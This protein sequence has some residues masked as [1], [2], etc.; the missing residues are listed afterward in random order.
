MFRASSSPLAR[1]LP[2]SGAINS[3]LHHGPATQSI[4]LVLSLTLSGGCGEASVS[5]PPGADGGGEHDASADGTAPDASIDGGDANPA[6][7]GPATRIDGGAEIDPGPRVD[8]GVDRDGG[9]EPDGGPAPD[10]G[11]ISDA[12]SPPSPLRVYLHPSGDDTQDGLTEASAVLTLVRV[13][14]IVEAIPEA[15]N[16]EVRIAPGTYF[17]QRVRWSRTF[18]RHSIR[19]TPLEEDGERPVFDGCNENDECGVGTWFHLDATSGEPTN[20]HFERI[21]VRRYSTALSFNGNREDEN[22][23]NGANRIDR[24]HFYDIGNVFDPSLRGSTAAVRFVN[25]DDNVITDSRFERVVNVGDRQEL[26]HGVYIAHTSDRNVI[27]G[28][29]F[30][31]S[32]G[33]PIRIRDFS[34]DNLIREN[35]FVRTGVLGAV[36]FWYCTGAR[37][38]KPTAECPSWRNQALANVFD[39]GFECDRIAFF[40]YA[41]GEDVAECSPVPSGDRR[42]RTSGNTVVDP[43]CV[44]LD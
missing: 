11:S 3:I 22:A 35:R 27:E 2:T 33:D 20:L 18:P 17:E 41:K 42:L 21:E 9:T 30:I 12:G 15:R 32:S 26:I 25:S 31:E 39:G 5:D 24:C 28:N 1:G 8:G 43:P 36:T 7:A 14:E 4:V 6:D 10:A 34:N 29:E 16:V 40:H 38:T 44:E 23:S 37:C 19:F 13:H